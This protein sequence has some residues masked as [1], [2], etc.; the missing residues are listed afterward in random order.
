[1]SRTTSRGEANVRLL[2]NAVGLSRQAIYSATAVDAPREPRDSVPRGVPAAELLSAIR[3]VVAANPGWG[4]RKVWA[5]LRRKKLLVS[6]RRVAEMMKAHGLSLAVPNSEIGQPTRGHVIV[7]ESNRRWCSDLTTVW[8]R[9]DGTIAV[10]P[11]IDC[12]DR[13][14]LALQASKSQDAPHI[15]AP[16][17]TALRNEFESSEN[18][19]DGLELRTDHGPQYT[20]SDAADL[21]ARWGVDHTFA[22]VRRPTGN[23]V[24]E[25][26]I[27]TLKLEL[28]W[29]RD[30]DSLEELQ[31][32]LRAWVAVYNT[33]RPHQ[34]LD[35][36]TP[37]E[38]RIGNLEGAF[39]LAA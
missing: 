27:L 14:C 29:T 10:V 30:W 24:A 31:E 33:E 37:A 18:V 28:I 12:G 16:I 32:A 20:G 35:W 3:G 34:A 23:A 8:T 6:R 1:M 36:Q 25:R 9:R 38:R 19:P 22:P 39:L 7:G 21:C 5:S 2:A 4:T 15:L 26:F 17:E 13:V 11:V